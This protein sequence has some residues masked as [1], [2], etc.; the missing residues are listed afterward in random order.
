MFL[1][2][3]LVKASR[4][5]FAQ[6]ITESENHSFI[7]LGLTLLIW[8][9]DHNYLV[10][11]VLHVLV[12][13]LR[14]PLLLP[15]DTGLLLDPLRAAGAGR[16]HGLLLLDMDTTSGELLWPDM[17]VQVVLFVF[18]VV[19]H[20]S[21]LSDALPVL[22][23]VLQQLV[24]QVPN[25]K[26]QPFELL[27][28]VVLELIHLHRTDLVAGIILLSVVVSPL[29]PLLGKLLL[30]LDVVLA[31]HVVVEGVLTRHLNQ[32]KLTTKPLDLGA[33]LLVVCSL[34]VGLHLVPGPDPHVA[35]LA[36]KLFLVE[37]VLAIV[38]PFAV[39]LGRNI[40]QPFGIKEPLLFRPKLPSTLILVP[41]VL[42]VVLI[43]R[44]KVIIEAL[45]CLVPH[46]VV[47]EASELH[48]V[49]GALEMTNHAKKVMIKSRR[50]RLKKK[51]TSPC[52]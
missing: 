20:L 13:I 10:V 17:V 15:L 41:E 51:L 39:E 40:I 1:H 16:V 18:L 43:G 49:R 35:D 52:H 42:V 2:I 44:D 14:P 45:P 5:K 31:S 21:V 28:L 33:L 24:P 37:F 46:F 29:F 6:I 34:F 12:I 26:S 50:T 36:V 3:F 4:F 38:I 48:Q 9:R 30:P 25:F 19:I 23:L 11:H 8:T 32:T 27:I 47:L 7:L 22:V